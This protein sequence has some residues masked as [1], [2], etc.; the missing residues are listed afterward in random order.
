M[1]EQ[2]IVGTGGTDLDDDLPNNVVDNFE[3]DIISYMLDTSIHSNG[4]LECNIYD[5]VLDFVFHEADKHIAGKKTKKD[6]CY[7]IKT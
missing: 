7:V 3:N 6:L 2:H 4:F 1:I 5:E